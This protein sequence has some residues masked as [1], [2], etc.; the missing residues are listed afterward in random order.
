VGIAIESAIGEGKRYYDFMR[1]DEKYKYSFTTLA[2]RS[3]TCFFARS[4]GARAYLAK[5]EMRE[6]AKRSLR[7]LQ[8]AV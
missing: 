8:R 4:V 3:V 2:R 5:L 6:H 1:G 7:A